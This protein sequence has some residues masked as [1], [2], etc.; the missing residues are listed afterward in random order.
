[1]KKVLLPIIVLIFINAFPLLIQAQPF[2]KALTDQEVKKWFNT[3]I[4]AHHLQIKYKSEEDKYDDVI[5]AYYEERNQWLETVGYD[6][7]DFDDL[8]ERINAGYSSME[9]QKSLDEEREGMQ[10]QIDEIDGLAML[11]PDQ[12]NMMKVGIL[13]GINEQQKVI[14]F[15]KPDWESLLPYKAEFQQLDDWIG[16]NETNPP[17]IN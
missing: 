12:K 10:S 4:D 3:M 5:V 8:T 11:S 9:D 13:K 7:V 16:E 15:F 2:E 6:P 14:D 1:M 17:V